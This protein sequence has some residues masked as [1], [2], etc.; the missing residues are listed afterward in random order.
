MKRIGI[1][2]A[3]GDTPA[4]NATI[5]GAVHR[6]NQLRVEVFGIIKGFSGLLN[7]QVPH[8]HL[9]PL[10]HSIP[11]LDPTRGGTILG[12]SRDY[13]DSDDTEMLARVA[14]RLG[15]LK[16]DGLVC[17]GGDGTLNGM[18]AL[19]N[20]LPVVLAPKT[21]DNDLGL[22]YPDEANEW[23]REPSEGPRG[24][25][26]EEAARARLPPRRDGQLR[27]AR[28]RHRGLRLGAERRA[29]PDHGREPPPDRDHR[30]HGPR[31]GHDRPG[32]RLRA[33]RHHPRARV[34]RRA[35]PARRAR[36]GH[37]RQAEARRALRLRRDRRHRG[38]DPRR[39]HRQQGP[40]RQP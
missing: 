29:D 24:Y 19:S 25:V 2:T 26:V 9:N 4:L 31:L 34:A 21:I 35:R 3:G 36:A 10:F 23:F 28:L 27:D 1:L 40:G 5:A 15:R 17:V 30:G 20:H 14:D 33:A 37:P 6:A 12:A 32:D 18:Q 7:P 22:N 13:V 16:I 39:G 11:E 38:A 8:V